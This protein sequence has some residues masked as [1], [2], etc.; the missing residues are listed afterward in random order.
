[1]DPTVIPILTGGGTAGLILGLV[2]AVWAFA[3]RRVITRGTFDDLRAERDKWEALATGYGKK[4]E[5][6]TRA[7]KALSKLLSDPSVSSSSRH[8]GPRR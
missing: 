6:Q 3:T 2:I 7:I 8:R 1:M 5:E 4:F